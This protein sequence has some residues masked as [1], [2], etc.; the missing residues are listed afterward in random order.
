[1]KGIIF[2]VLE[3]VVARQFSRDVW[4][5]LIDNAGVDGAYTSLGNYADE[6]FVSL[7]TTSAEVLGKTPGEILRWFGQSAIPLL[8]TRYPY[9][10]ESHR[11][12]RD[13]VLS[14][15]TIIHPE[16][17][18]IYAGA[19][20]PFF[21]FKPSDNGSMMMAYHSKRKMCMLAQG[22]IEGAANHYHDHA[23]VHHRECMLNGDKKCLLEIKWAA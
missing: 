14:V 20:C 1:M 16:V 8:A 7:V 6:E 5:D 3:E 15:N 17:H 19:S 4:E 21:H 9:L 11:S 12:S 2:N 22:F 23:D 18:K 10:F 13:F